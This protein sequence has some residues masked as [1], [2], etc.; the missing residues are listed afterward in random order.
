MPKDYY[1][2]LGVSRGANLN[3]IK[4]AYRT[5]IKQHHPDVTQTNGS[6]ERF[7]EIREAYETLSNEA[8]RKSYDAQLAEKGAHHS[9][10]D[11]AARALRVMSKYVV[12]VETEESK[13]RG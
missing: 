5:V 7:H 4:K 9:V 3:K 11:I 1:I 8:K 12:E 13:S 2:V 6:T 10:P